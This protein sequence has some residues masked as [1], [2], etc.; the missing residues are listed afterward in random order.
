MNIVL[1][2]Y[3]GVGK[4]HVGHLL[5]K[6]LDR[7]LVS[8]DAEIVKAAGMRIPEIVAQHGWPYFRDLETE[9]ARMLSGRDGLVIDCGGGVIERPENVPILKTNG[10]VFWLKAPVA[11]IVARIADDSERPALTSGKSFTEEVAEVLE[12]RS[13]LYRAAADVEID[14]DGCTPQ[15]VVDEILVR[16]QRQGLC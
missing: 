16:L 2:G 9:Q 7:R 13:P 8:M 6:Q 12:R 15:L 3:R 1:I 11:T 5:A 4:S 10:L 14:T